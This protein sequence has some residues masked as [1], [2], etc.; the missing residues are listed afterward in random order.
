MRGTWNE[1][2]EYASAL[3]QV[4]LL[5]MMKELSWI[6][7]R[8]KKILYDNYNSHGRNERKKI[9]EQ[10]FCA[11]RIALSPMNHQLLLFKYIDFFRCSDEVHLL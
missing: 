11:E 7:N 10:T 2:Q 4:I 1:T 9:Q 5:W 6:K 3:R 8:N